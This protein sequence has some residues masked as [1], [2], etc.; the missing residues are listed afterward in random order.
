MQYFDFLVSVHQNFLCVRKH[1]IVGFDVHHMTDKTK[2][3]KKEQQQALKC[4]KVENY[5]VN[6]LPRNLNSLNLSN[7]F[8]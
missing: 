7:R 3:W 1:S 8:K 6:I 4:S 5:Q 2:A